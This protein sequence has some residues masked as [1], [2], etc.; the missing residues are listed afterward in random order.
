M[1]ID[2]DI[3]MLIAHELHGLSA[4]SVKKMKP[5]LIPQIASDYG[6]STKEAEMYLDEIINTFKNSL[7]NYRVFVNI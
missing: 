2:K 5:T 4:E 3:L 7:I 1:K 6:I